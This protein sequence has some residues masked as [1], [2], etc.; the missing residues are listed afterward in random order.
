MTSKAL[1]WLQGQYLLGLKGPAQCVNFEDG[2]MK[3]HL[4]PRNGDKPI[5]SLA[6]D[7]DIEIEIDA[8]GIGHAC[9]LEQTRW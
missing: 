9:C 4:V 8:A 3:V 1:I 6:I 5:V 2:P 7:I